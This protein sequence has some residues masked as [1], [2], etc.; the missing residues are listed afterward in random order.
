MIWSALST[1]DNAVL[2]APVWDLKGVLSTQKVRRNSKLLQGLAPVAPAQH[3]QNTSIAAAFVYLVQFKPDVR[4]GQLVSSL[5]NLCYAAKSFPQY[6]IVLLHTELTLSEGM[7]AGI[8]NNP[9]VYA[10]CKGRKLD[11]VDVR[12]LFT[13]PDDFNKSGISSPVVMKWRSG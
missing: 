9:A 7:K 5:G 3:S 1:S 10:Q 2:S 13:F 11:F 8:E 4:R 12:K 6:P